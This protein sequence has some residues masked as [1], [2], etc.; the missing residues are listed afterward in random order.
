M[1]ITYSGD[2]LDGDK[3]NLMFGNHPTKT[4]WFF[5]FYFLAY[6]GRMTMVDDFQHLPGPGN[7]FSSQ[8]VKTNTKEIFF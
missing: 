3:R 4:D 6:K 7:Y 2:K 8:N 5:G 1:D